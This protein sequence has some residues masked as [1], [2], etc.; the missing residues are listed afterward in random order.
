MHLQRSKHQTGSQLA[1]LQVAANQSWHGW[2]LEEVDAPCSW[3]EVTCAMAPGWRYSIGGPWVETP[4]L[5]LVLNDLG[6]EGGLA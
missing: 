1:A 4:L 3:S 5:T 6:L 2:T